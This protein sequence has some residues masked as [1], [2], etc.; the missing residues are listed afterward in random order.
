MTMFEEARAI[1][2]L[3]SMQGKT[4][5]E[6]AEMM[7]TS[8]SYIA[9]KLRLLYLSDEEEKRITE[10]GLSERHARGLLRIKDRKERL[11]MI[12]KIHDMKLSVA[13]SD[14]LIDAELAYN[15]PKKIR[16]LSKYEGVVKFE[17]ILRD[18][19]RTLG[20]IGVGVILSESHGD[21]KKYI[22][23]AIDEI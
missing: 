18:S 8:Q 11:L 14:A 16:S 20:T 3:I 21:G 23:L 2:G 13:A 1:K 10:Y 7:G 6:L 17:K 9:N 22:T 12:E 15:E 4:Q 5:C 19:I